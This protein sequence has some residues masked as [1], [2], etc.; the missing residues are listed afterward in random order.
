MLK[1][2]R[3][4]AARSLVVAV[5]VV[6]LVAAALTFGAGSA[7]AQTRS[8]G[9]AYAVPAGAVTLRNLA[10]NECM[11]LAGGAAHN[12]AFIGRVHL[13]VLA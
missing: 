13:F 2:T 4:A 11:D 8:V 5:S 9:T 6:G 3:R 1:G 10:Y 7:A 12:G